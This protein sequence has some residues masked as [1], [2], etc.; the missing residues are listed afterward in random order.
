MTKASVGLVQADARVRGQA[1]AALATPVSR[2]Q[3]CVATASRSRR[4]FRLAPSATASSDLPPSLLSAR[5]SCLT[6]EL[7]VAGAVAERQP[8]GG[9]RGLRQRVR[10]ASPGR[11]PGDDRSVG[12][13]RRLRGVVS[14]ASACRV[15]GV[16][17][18]RPHSRLAWEPGSEKR[19]PPALSRH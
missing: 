16:E 18:G 5:T 6:P 11:R 7:R 1:S 4:R 8:A 13:M 12:A 15:V 2:K 10:S 19:L 14:H 3:A 9:A 17:R